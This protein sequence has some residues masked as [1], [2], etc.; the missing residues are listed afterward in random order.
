MSFLKYYFFYI[1]TVD[2]PE[3]L[4]K[5]KY[6]QHKDHSLLYFRPIQENDKIPNLNTQGQPLF[7]TY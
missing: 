3:V 4:S 7:F 2:T 5:K 6:K 1:I